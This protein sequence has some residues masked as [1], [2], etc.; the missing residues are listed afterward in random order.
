MSVSLAYLPFAESARIFI[1]TS[2]ELNR[3]DTELRVRRVVSDIVGRGV[4]LIQRMDPETRDSLSGKLFSEIKT[5]L[6]LINMR[7]NIRAGA[8]MNYEIQDFGNEATRP[9]FSAVPRKIE[10]H[11]PRARRSSFFSCDS[12]DIDKARGCDFST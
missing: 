11:H 5:L 7:V 6:L 9:T 3:R 8:R 2:A 4:Y 10:N 12:L 1:C